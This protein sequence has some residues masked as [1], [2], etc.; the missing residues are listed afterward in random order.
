MKTENKRLIKLKFSQTTLFFALIMM[1]V[2]AIACVSPSFLTWRNIRNVFMQNAITGIIVASMTIV[3]IAGGIDLA[4]GNQLSFLG[5]LLAVLINKG[6]PE[7]WSVLIVLAIST[8]LCAISGLIIANTTAQ[9]FIITLGFMSVY[10]ALALITAGGSDIPIR[11]FQWLGQTQLLGV[12]IPVWIFLFLFLIVALV[13]QFT[14]FG[15]SVYSLG[16]N[17]QAAYISGIPVKRLKVIVYAIN[18]LFI[19]LAAAAMLSRLGSAVPTMADGYEMTVIAACA[20]GGITLTGGEGSALGSFLGLLFLGIVRNGLNMMSVP[21][22]Y[23]YLVN[24]TIIVIAVLLSNYNS[25]KKA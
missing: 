19:G 13:L 2:V 17:E 1:L 21:T 14:K 25:R 22:F 4:V 5:C 18:G 15:R 3:M 6:I 16:S 23:Q 11:S 12:I 20:I 10:K 24:G 7:G 9:P 8:L